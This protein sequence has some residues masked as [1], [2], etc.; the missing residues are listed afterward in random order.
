MTP[1]QY[2]VEEP[3]GLEIPWY[4]VFEGD[5]VTFRVSDFPVFIDSVRVVTS[6]GSVDFDVEVD[7]VKYSPQHFPKLMHLVPFSYTVLM[8][9]PFILF[10]L[11]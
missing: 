11:Q 3:E 7:G 8:S 6:G 10:K 5:E 9:T 4:P 1:E 2:P